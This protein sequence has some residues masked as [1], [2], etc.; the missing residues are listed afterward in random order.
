MPLFIVKKEAVS[1]TEGTII[2]EEWLS[3]ILSGK[4]TMEVKSQ[5][6]PLQGQKIALGYGS[7]VRGYAKVKEVVSIPYN[8]IPKHQNLHLATTWL[9]NHY[10]GKDVVYGY[11][12]EDVTMENKQVPYPRS[13][14]SVWFSIP[15]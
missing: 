10:R 7:L 12:L 8:D 4:K 1:R 2:R 14:G 9:M 3:L 15:F 6:K 5:Y 11:V 13:Y